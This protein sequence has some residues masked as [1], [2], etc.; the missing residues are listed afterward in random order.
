MRLTALPFATT[1]LLA[2]C[3]GSE[4]PPEPAA[5]PTASKREP[6]VLDAQLQALD[7]AKAMEQTLQ[8]QQDD[9]DKRAEALEKGD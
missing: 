6:T 9:L 3:G 8:K 7:K 4:P 1:L 2:A 5:S